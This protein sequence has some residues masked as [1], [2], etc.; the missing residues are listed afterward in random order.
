MG[1]YLRP[2]SRYWIAEVTVAGKRYRKSTGTTSKREARN[3]EQ[4]WKVELRE[5][6]NQGLTSSLTLVD[7]VDRYQREDL[8]PRRQKPD[9]ARKAQHNLNI[10]KA[11]FGSQLRVHEVRTADVSAWRSEMLEKGLSAATVNRRLADL[12]AI[13]RRAK[14]WGA[15]AHL[16]RFDMVKQ[17]QPVERY[18]TDQDY[19]RLL[20]HCPTHLSH[21]VIF[22]A[23]TGARLGEATAL[24]WGQ[25][26]LPVNG[27]RG[28]VT[29]TQ[30]KSGKSRGVPLPQDVTEMLWRIK[31]S[32]PEPHDRVFLYRR[33]DGVEMPFDSP[34]K[35]WMRAR[36]RAKLPWLRLHDLRHYYAA[37]L[38]RK[39]VSLYSV[40]R[41]LGHSNPSLTQRYAALRPEDLEG[42]VAVLD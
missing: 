30:T 16:P 25:V 28:R 17:A 35:S 33:E 32:R 22:L 40:Q 5:R 26:A 13:L 38:V 6:A 37:R 21:L 27:D 24:T 3:V 2:G 9:T 10:I 14:R 41:L 39:G 15:L 18:L 1:I 12:R 36:E 7:A 20:G 8:G 11:H 31:P 34:K 19:E 4:A 23:G 29:F 42:Q